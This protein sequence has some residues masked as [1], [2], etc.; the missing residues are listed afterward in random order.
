MPNIASVLK[1]EVVRLARKEVRAETE[2]LKKAVAQHR[3]DLAGLKRQV[4]ELERQLGRLE[5]QAPK[6]VSPPAAGDATTRLR[7]SAKGLATQRERLGL[8]ASELGALLNVSAQT[9]YNWEGEKSRP[10]Q[11]QLLALTAIRGMGKREAKAKLAEL[12][13]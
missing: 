9:V 6:S 1:E 13:A 11:Q 4:A 2:R 7:F 12:T 8:T 3:S 5:K 10:R